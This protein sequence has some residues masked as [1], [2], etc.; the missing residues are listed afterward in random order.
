MILYINKPD[1]SAFNT[2]NVTNIENTLNRSSSFNMTLYHY[3]I[4]I[5]L[6]TYNIFFN[7]LV[8]ILVDISTFNKMILQTQ[9]VCFDD[10]KVLL[11]LI[12]L[13]LKH[14]ILQIW[15]ITFFDTL[16]LITWFI[17]V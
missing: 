12:Y 3:L 17:N 7:I 8:L 13:Y 9:I 10:A 5:I 16:A 2:N 4:Q 6:Q 11:Y 15:V 14:V 1:L